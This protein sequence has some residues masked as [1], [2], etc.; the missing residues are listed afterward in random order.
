MR[1]LFFFVVQLTAIFTNGQKDLNLGDV[2][3]DTAFNCSDS[4]HRKFSE[5]LFS[6]PAICD[7]KNDIE[8]RLN[9]SSIRLTEI[10][11]FSYKDGKWDAK[12]YINSFGRLG[13]K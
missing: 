8:I 6:I 12:K 11:I 5:R 2:I 3:T 9:G 10:I 4:P 1:L 7:S 13:R